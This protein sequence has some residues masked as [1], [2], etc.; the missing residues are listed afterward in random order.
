MRLRPGICTNAVGEYNPDSSS[1]RNYLLKQKV[2]TSLDLED[3]SF[4]GSGSSLPYQDES[5]PDGINLDLFS[6]LKVEINNQ[7]AKFMTI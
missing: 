3:T 2:I 1:N 4:T 6:K 7:L 5:L